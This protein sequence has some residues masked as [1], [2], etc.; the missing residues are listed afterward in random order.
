MFSVSG[1]TEYEMLILIHYLY[2][3]MIL[4]Q[5]IMNNMRNERL[6]KNGCWNRANQTQAF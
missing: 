2:I 6:F 5:H 3:I 1:F 4:L